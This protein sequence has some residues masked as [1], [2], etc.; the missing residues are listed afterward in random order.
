[1]KPP[2]LQIKSWDRN[3]VPWHAQ[4]PSG[5]ACGDTLQ[6]SADPPREP[7]RNSP[8]SA[9]LRADAVRTRAELLLLAAPPPAPRMHRAR[10]RC[11]APSNWPIVGPRR[12]CRAAFK[13][14]AGA[15]PPGVAVARVKEA[16]ARAG[17]PRAFGKG[18]PQS[19]EFRCARPRSIVLIR[20]PELPSWGRAAPGSEAQRVSAAPPVASGRHSPP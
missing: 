10:R 4:L 18:C 17:S 12:A 11:G 19:W 2:H 5:Q 20:P 15:G 7:R 1:M 9:R 8:R 6:R 13:S 16:V 14:Q 3:H